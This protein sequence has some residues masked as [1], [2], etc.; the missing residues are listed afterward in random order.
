[1][2]KYSNNSSCS[3]GVS[4]CIW[5]VDGDE[6]INS[7]L[8]YMEFGSSSLSLSHKNPWSEWHQKPRTGSEFH[9][10]HERMMEFPDDVQT[11]PLSFHTAC[12][13]AISGRFLYV[14]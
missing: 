9:G 12:R 5:T 2:D 6:T 3:S 13:F 7:N 1:M 11:H 10:K 8:F 4:G 14:I